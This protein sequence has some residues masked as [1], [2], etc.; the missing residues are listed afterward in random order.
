LRNFD[1]ISVAETGLSLI[2]HTAIR[3]EVSKVTRIRYRWLQRPLNVDWVIVRLGVSGVRDFV[4]IGVVDIRVSSRL[5][6]EIKKLMNELLMIEIL[7]LPLNWMRLNQVFLVDVVLG[8]NGRI[9]P[10]LSLTAT[11][12]CGISE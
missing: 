11:R 9:E 6:P 1:W 3:V 2:W 12:G 4:T 10:D 8:D 7:E 5:N